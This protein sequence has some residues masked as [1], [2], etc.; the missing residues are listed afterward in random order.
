MEGDRPEDL[1]K[2]VDAVKE[3]F[4]REV[5]ERELTQKKEL[6]QKVE[7]A[8][9]A[10]ENQMRGKP[11]FSTEPRLAS[12]PVS[13][14]APPRQMPGAMPN[15]GD[16]ANAINPG[17][18]PIQQTSSVVP[19]PPGAVNAAMSGLDSDAIK[20]VKYG[21]L[22]QR[23]TS[24][25]VFLS[26]DYPMASKQRQQ[27]LEMVKQ[28]LEKFK[29]QAPPPELFAAIEKDP[30]VM[31][32]KAEA[33]Y[34]R[35]DIRY[36]Q[37]VTNNPNSEAITLKM[38]QAEAKEAEV[39]KLIQEKAKLYDTTTR[40]AEGDRLT[41]LLENAER[42]IKLLDEQR[43]ITKK[44][45]EDVKK[46]LAEMPP[47]IR[48]E[49]L[50]KPLVDPNA[51]D[52]LMHDDKYRQLTGHWIVLDL[53]L[54]SPTRVQR[55]QSASLPS[56]K[57]TKKQIIATVGAGL[58]GFVLM[59]VGVVALE[60][61]T[62]RISSL[63]EL[64]GNISTPVVGVLPWAPDGDHDTNPLKRADLVEA[65]DKLRGQVVQSYLSRGFSIVTVTSPL[66]DEGRSYTAHQLARSLSESGTRT[67]L[68]DFDL[69]QPTMHNLVG[70]AN[71]KGLCEL[72][73]GEIN[74]NEAQ[75]LLPNGMSFIPAGQWSEEARRAAVS[76]KVE[77]LIKSWRDQFDCVILHG[78]ALLTVAESV[79]VARR[80]DVILLCTLY[81][82][83]RLP[84]LK[85]ATD[86]LA[87]M[88]VAQSALVY[89]GASSQ[90][91]QC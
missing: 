33:D 59:A 42:N 81:R 39:Q 10:L 57:D 71:D 84:L 6:K 29:N 76:A 50:K 73:R 34:I 48:K 64:T 49:E 14:A 36:L 22:T 66:A 68:V 5:V 88:D 75:I 74:A 69:R 67:L 8:R 3:A 63:S 30:E 47:E 56:Q 25:E 35:N 7:I 32:K 86:R 89:L 91:S 85:R 46:E 79:E 1:R 78:H 18:E 77:S 55:L 12:A 82:E 15:V 17:Q 54:Q 26:Q 53:E 65:V 21:S 87:T 43:D 44:L 19:V 11:G 80:S 52:L 31:R 4:M 24:Y 72:L 9:T 60:T 41:K 62:R 70:L 61:R 90:E 23:Y 83:T 38:R 40:K 28:E 51:T 16:N 37:G 58:M 20:K 45:L 13:P 2:I 27:T